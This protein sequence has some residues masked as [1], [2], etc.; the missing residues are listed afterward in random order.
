LIFSFDALST[1]LIYVIP[2]FFASSQSNLE[3]VRTS[4][5]LNNSQA[6]SGGEFRSAP[7][8]GSRASSHNEESDNEPMALEVAALRALL[9]K[10]EQEIQ[11]LQ[12]QTRSRD[13]SSVLEFQDLPAVSN[14]RSDEAAG[15][16]S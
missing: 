7:I 12:A 3:S 9:A 8:F 2:K 10:R 14:D 13:G 15:L 11:D 4:G 6:A 1:V 5:F 16:A